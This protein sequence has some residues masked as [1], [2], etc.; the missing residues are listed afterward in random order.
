LPA[1]ASFTQVESLVAQMRQAWDQLKSDQIDEDVM[2]F[3]RSVSS[4]KATL[5]HVTPEVRAWLDK[6]NLSTS[7]KVTM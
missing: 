1:E 6:N 5:V 7:F 2:L 3:L 4:N